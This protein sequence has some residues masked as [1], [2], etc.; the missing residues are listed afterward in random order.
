MFDSSHLE[1]Q[2]FKSQPFNSTQY[3]PKSGLFQTQQA[4]DPALLPLVFAAQKDPALRSL[5]VTAGLFN[6]GL[7]MGWLV[8]DQ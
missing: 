2:T 8:R 4:A 5:A 6:G 3:N 7:F 1:S